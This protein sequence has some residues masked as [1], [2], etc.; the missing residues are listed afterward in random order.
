M[1]SLDKTFNKIYSMAQNKVLF[2]KVKKSMIIVTD[3]LLSSK[4]ATVV[5]FKVKVRKQNPVTFG[6]LCLRDMDDQPLREGDP[7]FQKIANKLLE[8][9]SGKEIKGFQ[10]TD[11]P[12]LNKEG[13]PTGMFWV[14]AV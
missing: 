7:E 12:V 14:E 13:N 2:H 8:L 11:S 3:A 4:E 6:I 1:L 5:G 9:G 10:F